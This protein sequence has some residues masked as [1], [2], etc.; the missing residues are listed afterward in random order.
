[1]QTELKN[2][3]KEFLE[4]EFEGDYNLPSQMFYDDFPKEGS[5]WNGEQELQVLN[6]AREMGLTVELVDSYGGEDCGREYWSVYSFTD[7]LQ[8]V[9]VK[10]DGWY[11]SYHGSEYEEW[12]F[13]KPKEVTVTQFFKE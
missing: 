9:Y 5:K 10:F 11:A 6:K 1:M 4:F 2:K 3:V 7:G 8:V 12:Y 13:V